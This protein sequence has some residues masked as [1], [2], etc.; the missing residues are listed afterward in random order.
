MVAEAASKLEAKKANALL[1]GIGDLATLRPGATKRLTFVFRAATRADDP[2][3]FL[4]HFKTILAAGPP[5]R[6][7]PLD[8]ME[9]IGVTIERASLRSVGEAG[10][11]LDSVDEMLDAIA[12]HTPP[13][14][15]AD[16]APFLK[17]VKRAEDAAAFIDG[18][19]RLIG[20]LAEP[21]AGLPKASLARIGERLGKM[22]RGKIQDFIDGA[23]RLVA[24]R[25]GAV[26]RLSHLLEAATKVDNPSVFLDQVRRI[27]DA[28]G[29]ADELVGKIGRKTGRQS[30]ATASAYVEK[31][32]DVLEQTPRRPD[33]KG[34]SDPLEDLLSAST[35]RADPVGYLDA[36][37][38]LYT[39]R[40][41]LNALTVLARKADAGSIDLA[42]LRSKNL[43]NWLLDF[44]GRNPRTSWGTFKRASRIGA[45]AGD[46]VVIRARS[47]LRGLAGEFAAT[48]P[49][50][51]G[52]LAT[53][54]R[55]IDLV[56]EVGVAGT[57]LDYLAETADGVFR[58]L[59]IKAWSKSYWEKIYFAINNMFASPKIYQ[60]QVKK[61][62]DSLRRML[63]QLKA[64][65]DALG[66]S[67]ILALSDEFQK[68]APDTRRSLVKFIMTNAPPGT[69]IVWLDAAQIRMVAN[70][71]ARQL[72]I[73]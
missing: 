58:R 7:L 2:A 51:T 52:Q 31:L 37:R 23:A 44:L 17:A 43:D 45:K 67:P 60:E 14:V 68:L 36:A 62:L 9:A 28:L 61:P 64:G 33:L 73:P 10:R 40:I 3:A 4:K 49:L 24:E 66:A 70:D 50:T 56:P 53:N 11:L 41:S 39:R 54:N 57:I 20:G 71:L 22:P 13:G 26:R 48:L 32:V 65:R 19:S 46:P 63:G 21:G 1:V 27:S 5:K 15:P 34:V 55:I 8:A 16:L 29:D 35:K 47:K 42:W 6:T 72:D 12:R 69:Q 18:V 25:P 59:E 30:G 38:A